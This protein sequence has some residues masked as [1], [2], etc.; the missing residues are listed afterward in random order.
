MSDRFVDYLAELETEAPRRRRR[1]ATSRVRMAPSEMGPRIAFDAP[2]PPEAAA[3]VRTGIER[4]RRTD[5]QRRRPAN[6]AVL[7][8]RVQ[9]VAN[10]AGEQDAILLRAALVDVAALAERWAAE[11]PGGKRA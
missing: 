6:L 11:L 2:P 4:Q 5:E 1:P 3:I 10:A 7:L 8:Q 9:A